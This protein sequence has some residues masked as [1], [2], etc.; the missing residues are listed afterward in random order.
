MYYILCLNNPRAVAC[1]HGDP[2]EQRH[3]N[4]VER[5]KLDKA[6]TQRLQAGSQ[7]SRV[8][9][10]GRL[11]DSEPSREPRL[12]AAAW[13]A[14]GAVAGLVCAGAV[15]ALLSSSARLRRCGRG[16]RRHSSGLDP[17]A[18][19]AAVVAGGPH[20]NL[21]ARLLEENMKLR[22]AIAYSSSATAAATA[23]AAVADRPFARVRPY[24]KSPAK[25][26]DLPSNATAGAHCSCRTSAPHLSAIAPAAQLGVAAVPRDVSCRCLVATSDRRSSRSI[27]RYNL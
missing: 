5:T 1:R 23:S 21:L 8:T 20:S 13:G 25:Y 9:N 3:G 14:T 18:A 7:A 26:R 24:K 19:S 27:C 22:D 16:R 11:L 4:N 6:K 12:A 10:M 17:A 15:R 2:A